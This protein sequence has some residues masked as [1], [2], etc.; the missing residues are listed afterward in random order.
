MCAWV[1]VCLCVCVC[2]CVCVGVCMFA[3]SIR[4][5]SHYR[6]IHTHV[7]HTDA[8]LLH[9]GSSNSTMQQ[10]RCVWIASLGSSQR[11]TGSDGRF[12][13]NLNSAAQHHLSVVAPAS[14]A[15]V[16]AAAAAAAAGPDHIVGRR[17]GRTAYRPFCLVREKCV[18]VF[19][20]VCA[21]MCGCVCVCVCL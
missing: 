15:A 14:A 9:T 10:P 1:C 18:R 19:V 12:E 17:A 11:W 8:P 16:S 13:T 20:C 3:K 4:F 7:H 6:M 5:L 2:V 21:H